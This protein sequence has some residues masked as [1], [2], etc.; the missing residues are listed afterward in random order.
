MIKNLNNLSLKT[1]TVSLDG[2][3]EKNNDLIRGQGTFKKI[4]TGLYNLKMLY[5]H[6]YCIKMTLMKTNL[7]DIENAILIGLETG[8]H[9]VKFNCVRKDGRAALNNNIVL[10]R[11]EYIE[12]IKKIEELKLKYKDKISIRA[13]LNI[14]CEEEYNYIPELGFGCFAGKESMCIDACG[15]VKPCSHF[16]EKF[17]CGNI[18]EKNLSEIWAN[19]PI[20]EQFRSF[21]GN[22]ECLSC[23]SYD[24]CRGGCRYRAFLFGNINGIDPYCYEKKSRI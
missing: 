8:C 6:N 13:P 19:S 23:H 14:Y 5:K 2:G 22:T 10:N 24:K 18:K 11:D 12:V 15:N 1:L 17:I 7:N 3:N 16:P 20:L 9:S 21:Q 4:I